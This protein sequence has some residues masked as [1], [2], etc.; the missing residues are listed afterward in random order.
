MAKSNLTVIL[1]VSSRGGGQAVEFSLRGKPSIHVFRHWLLG[2]IGVW[3][4]ISFSMRLA[5]GDESKCLP[6]K[7]PAV[8]IDG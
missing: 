8:D 2:N 6:R 4:D 5:R 3:R 1:C 7:R